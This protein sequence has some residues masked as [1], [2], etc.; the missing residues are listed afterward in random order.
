M[1]PAAARERAIDQPAGMRTWFQLASSHVV[2][3]R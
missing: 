2:S 1:A 3:G